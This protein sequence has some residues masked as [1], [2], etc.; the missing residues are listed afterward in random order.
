MKRVA[1]PLL[2][3]L[4]LAATAAGALLIFDAGYARS[5][6]QGNGPVPREFRSQAMFLALA[7]PFGWM[8]S[9]VRA[10]RWRR[11]SPW[12]FA[13]SILSLVA[14][15]VVGH[16]MNGAQ[17]WIDV[18]P[19]SVQ[20]AE[21][22][23]LAAVM[24]LA[25]AFA[26][27]KPWVAPKRPPGL[28]SWLDRVA[29]PKGVRAAPFLLVLVAVAMIEQEPDLGTAA[30][31]AA[32]AF[33][34]LWLGG[35]SLKS[36]VAVFLVGSI[37]V[38]AMVKSEPYRMDRIVNH[39]QRWSPEHV[40]DVGYQT[41]QSEAAMAA[42]ALTG[43]GIGSGRAKHMMPAATTDF[44]MAT[45]GEEFGLLGSLAI[46]GLLG[47][48]VA[49]LF[50]LAAR[51][52]GEYG[53]LVLGGVGVWLAVQ[54]ATNVAMANGALPPIGIPLPFISS[55]GSSL[56]ALWLAVGVCQSA[57]A[58]HAPAAKAAPEAPTR[59]PARMANRGI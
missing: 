30:V 11:W 40:D 46:I 55:G 43:V 18:G 51:A 27:R 49:R 38:A 26:G 28:A 42:G 44:I 59:F 5:I 16:E 48:I 4:A 58:Q 9:Q 37:G 35:V 54:T 1:D 24:F 33:G 56:L 22:A 31:I 23:K 10:E 13:L 36:I 20:P 3:M 15:K 47:A 50:W 32:T 52:G 53:S 41:T 29:V 12:L 57:A 7:L 34:M 19:F 6:A 8:V 21:F 17:R 14:V 39:A 2:L 25:W 45:V